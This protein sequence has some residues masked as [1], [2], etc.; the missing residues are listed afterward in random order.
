[1]NVNN[2]SE[3]ELYE[4]ACKYDE[5]VDWKHIRT[6][7]TEV[8]PWRT[9]D[10]LRRQWDHHLRPDV[11][12]QTVRWTREENQKL[13]QLVEEADAGGGVDWHA[14]TAALGASLDR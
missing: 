5:L 2:V 9:V 7:A 6:I 3:Q 12:H 13:N 4:Y 10:D 8:A 1:M 14:I 11:N